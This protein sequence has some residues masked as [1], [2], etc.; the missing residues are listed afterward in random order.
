[1]AGGRYILP[2]Q[3]RLDEEVLSNIHQF[4]IDSDR[5]VIMFGELFERFKAELLDKTSITNRFYLQ[6]VLRYK[7]EKEFYFAKDLLIKDINSEQGIKLSIAIELF[8]KEQGRIVTKDE[9]K[10]EFLGLADFV[11]QA[12]TANNSDILL[13]DSGKYLHSEQIIA[14]NAIKERLKKILDDC[15][16]QGSVS[17]R[18]LYDDIYVQENE[19]LINNNIEGHIALYSVLNFWFLD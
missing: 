18:K 2:D 12:A 10:E 3:I 11:L 13:W 9:L 7:Y 4:I 1:M 17:V 19:F 8:I 16:S 6:G 5:N 14:D 15:T